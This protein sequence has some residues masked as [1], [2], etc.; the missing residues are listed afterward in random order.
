[1]DKTGSTQGM[2]LR[3][4]PPNK[5]IIIIIIKEGPGYFEALDVSTFKGAANKKLRLLSAITTCASNALAFINFLL[6]LKV[7]SKSLASADKEIIGSI[8]GNPK[9]VC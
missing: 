7:V 3:I 9:P 2:P 5:A 6:K 8:T 1:M 4:N